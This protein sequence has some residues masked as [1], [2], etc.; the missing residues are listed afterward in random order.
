MVLAWDIVFIHVPNLLCY[1]IH[2]VYMLMAI[3]RLFIRKIT[4]GNGLF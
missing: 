1:N 2:V 4:H 3:Q